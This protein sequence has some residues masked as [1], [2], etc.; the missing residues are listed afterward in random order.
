LTR[1]RSVKSTSPPRFPFLT[2]ECL[3]RKGR[4]MRAPKPIHRKHEDG[5]RTRSGRMSNVE[6]WA[7]CNESLQRLSDQCLVSKN[8]REKKTRGLPEMRENHFASAVLA[9]PSV[10]PGNEL[11]PL[12]SSDARVNDTTKFIFLEIYRLCGKHMCRALILHCGQPRPQPQS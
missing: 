10:E 3:A 6:K 12:Y 9:R 2:L 5:E 4:N 8:I 1:R 11:P 7:P